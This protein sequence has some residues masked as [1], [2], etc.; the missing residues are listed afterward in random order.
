MIAKGNKMKHLDSL[1]LVAVAVVI[2]A[3]AIARV[4]AAPSAPTLVND[5]NLVKV[6][7][8]AKRLTPAQKALLAG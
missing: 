6:V 7:V 2:S 4:P 8:T 1:F 5:T 3:T